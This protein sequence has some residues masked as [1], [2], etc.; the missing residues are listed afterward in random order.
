MSSGPKV[1]GSAKA[2]LHKHRSTHFK[3]VIVGAGSAGISVA[4]RLR[5]KGES[6]IAIIDPAT[7][8][9][10]QPLWTLV[11]AGEASAVSTKRLQ[12]DLIPQG[13]AWY[14]ESVEGIDP[15]KSE[16]TTDSGVII[17]YDCLVVCPGIELAWDRVPGLE[18]AMSTPY[19][20]S[21]YTVDLAP[22]TWE[23]VQKFNG[24][25]ALF[26]APG[27]P[28]KCPGAPQ[29][30]AYLS[31]DEWQRRSILSKTD[32]IF[33]TGAGGIFGVPEFAKV[34][35]EVVE[36]YGIDARFNHELIKVDPDSRDATFQ[37]T[38]DGVKTESTIRYDLLVATPPQRAPSFIRESPL[39]HPD[40]PLGWVPVDKHTLRDIRYAN[41]FALGDVSDAPTSKTGAAIRKQAPVVV[42]NVL[43]TLSNRKLPANYD[44][45]AACP[46]TTAKGKMLLAEFDYTLKPCPSFPVINTQKERTDMWYVKKYGLPAFYWNL[47]LKGR[48]K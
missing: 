14:R 23:L 15:G 46:F 13:V 25:T 30:A 11:G 39:A 31:S 1:E 22:K 38:T 10:Y 45:Y 2:N 3:I 35:R 27:T 24:G 7:F 29:K 28:V 47:M 34:L 37:V 17:G 26:T 18:E 21:N 20:S 43:A 19:A 48:G 33:A 4:S 6:D 40:N 32:V 12:A 5:N 9:Y 42:E 8:H 41:I 44:G 36:R 16:L